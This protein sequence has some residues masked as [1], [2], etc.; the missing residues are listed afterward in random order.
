MAL[1][2]GMRN[3]AAP[4]IGTLKERITLMQ[5]PCA[6]IASA[7]DARASA[8]A[9][10]S[11]CRRISA[12]ASGRGTGA[13]DATERVAAAPDADIEAAEL[14]YALIHRAQIRADRSL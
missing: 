1:T 8:T 7:L 2:P 6:I 14:S 4:S 5:P 10:S 13:T 9:S 12:C 3:W 11:R